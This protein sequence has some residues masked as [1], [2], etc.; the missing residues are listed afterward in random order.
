MILELTF[1][2]FAAAFVSALMGPVIIGSGVMDMPDGRRR[3]HNGPTPKAGGLAAGIGAAAGVAALAFWQD[4]QWS[5]D[6]APADLVRTGLVCLFG[7]I[8]L[9]LGLWDDLR[10]PGPQLKFGLMAVFSL[11]LAVIAV[12][13]QAFLLPG[14]VVADVGLVAGALGSALWLFTMINATNF[15]DGAN[16]LAMGSL[17]IGL[18]GLGLLGLIHNAPHAAL[19]AFA[20]VGG[21]IGLIAWNFPH[22]RL[23]AGD[24]GA[25]FGG[26]MAAGVG[27][28]LVQDGGVS[29]LVPPIL[30]FP[31]LAD[32]LLTL[33]Y[34]VN[35]KR[36]ILQGHR[37]HMY[38]IALRAGAAPV[39]VTLLYWGLTL[40][41]VALGAMASLAARA[42]APEAFA[43]QPGDV[44]PSQVLLIQAAA[45]VASV[46]PW[47]V[48]AG[49]AG[50][51]LAVSRRVRR[52]ALARGLTSPS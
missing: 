27:L 30:F 43:P 38:Q 17:A 5:A 14:G 44:A 26:A 37:E 23:F 11:A 15:M 1:A 9:G 31:I 35:Q 51:A 2:L 10:H 28:L 22:G 13:A 16:G 40:G 8:I 21:L 18:G 50:V 19:L 49:L 29:P 12:R 41:C 7:L 34:R 36:D 4:P 48:L 46:T 45:W 3:L 39:R 24:T 20:M 33:A 52:F 6:L 42:A 47:M 25:L 32:V